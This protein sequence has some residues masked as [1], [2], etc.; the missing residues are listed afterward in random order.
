MDANEGQGEVAQE[1]EVQAEQTVVVNR[2]KWEMLKYF[3]IGLFYEKGE[4]SLTRTLA[5]IAFL[6][7]AGVSIYL[8]VKNEHWL[9]YDT[10]AEITGGGGRGLRLLD[11]LGMNKFASPPNVPYDKK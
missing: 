8:V 5:A 9:S 3:L 4:P 6:L 10:F 11:K 7:F 1:P 2:T